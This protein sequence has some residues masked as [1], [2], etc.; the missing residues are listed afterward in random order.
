MHSFVIHGNEDIFLVYIGSFNVERYRRQAIVKARF[1]DSTILSKLQEQRTRKTDTIF[2]LHVGLGILTHLLENKEWIGDIY[3]GLPSV[4][5]C[6]FQS[7]SYLP[8]VSDIS[9]T[10]KLPSCLTSR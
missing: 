1:S 5:G 4:Y 3:E 6:V 7:S 10:E 9:R 8:V 2:S